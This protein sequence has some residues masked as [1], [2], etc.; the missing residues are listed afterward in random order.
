[1]KL[2]SKAIGII[3]QGEGVIC[4]RNIRDGATDGFMSL[5]GGTK[6]D[7][8]TINETLVR[9]FTEEVGVVPDEYKQVH[10]SRVLHRNERKIIIR[11][12]FLINSYTGEINQYGCARDTTSPEIIPFGDLL[13]KRVELNQAHAEGLNKSVLE[14]ARLDA[15][16]TFFMSSWLESIH[17]QQ[18]V[19]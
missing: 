13:L 3:F 11:H 19:H 12:F 1:M 18:A 4:V 9:E 15:E 10:C 5:P 7:H 16:F 14:K 17:D 2:F 6:K 8:E